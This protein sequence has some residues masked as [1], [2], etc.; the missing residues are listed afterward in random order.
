M[1]ERMRPSWCLGCKATPFCSQVRS[2]HD[3]KLYA[4]HRMTRVFSLLCAL[5]RVL[6]GH[7]LGG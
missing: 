5:E 4:I 2:T 7:W 1:S 6:Q 3:L